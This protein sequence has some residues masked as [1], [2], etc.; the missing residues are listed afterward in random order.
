M[1]VRRAWHKWLV[2]FAEV[3]NRLQLAKRSLALS[4]HERRK[5][6]VLAL[7]ARLLSEL[8]T[9][10]ILAETKRD[11]AFRTT[12]RSI[13]ECALHLEMAETDPTYLTRLKDDDDASR[14]SRAIRFRSKSSTLTTEADKTLSDFIQ[15]MPK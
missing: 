6:V 14:R 2:D 15:R 7:Y 3:A 11:L 10:L 13:I 12:C 4:D 8:T 1:T 9:A 5:S